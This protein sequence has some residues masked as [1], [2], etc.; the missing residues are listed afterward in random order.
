MVHHALAIHEQVFAKVLQIAQAKKLMKGKSVT[1]DSTLIESEAAMKSI[2]RRDSGDDWKEYV[3]KLS[4][5][6]GIENPT[7]EDLRK[8]D[9]KRKGKK[10]SNDEWYNPND[11]DARSAKMKGGR[12]HQPTRP[13]T[14]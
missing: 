10:V 3:R 11:P 9:K 13:N 8:F 4:A 12:T 7:D 6:E 5:E 1:V 2:V 14:R